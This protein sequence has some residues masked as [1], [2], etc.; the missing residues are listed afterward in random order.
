MRHHEPDGDCTNTDGRQICGISNNLNVYAQYKDVRRKTHTFHTTR[1]AVPRKI[2]SDLKV[3]RWQ[4]LN[5]WGMD[6]A[7]RKFPEEGTGRFYPG[8]I[9]L[10]QTCNRPAIPSMILAY[11]PGII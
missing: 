9:G 7:M 4:A 10:Q 1:H 8:G 11:W 3:V 6:H 5:Y 2:L